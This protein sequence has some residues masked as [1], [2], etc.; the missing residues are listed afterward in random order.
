MALPESQ[1]AT[2]TEEHTPMEEQ[3]SH[4]IDGR[5]DVVLVVGY[6]TKLRVSSSVLANASE[7]FANLL[8]SPNFKEGKQKQDHVSEGTQ[9]PLEVE[10][11]EDEPSGMLLLC[12]LLHHRGPTSV[13]KLSREELVSIAVLANKYLIRRQFRYMLGEAIIIPAP[14]QS[15]HNALFD[16]HVISY[17]LESSKLFMTASDYLVRTVKLDDNLLEDYGDS[18]VWKMM[19]DKL[20]GKSNGVK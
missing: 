2:P 16:Y 12:Q 5:G 14:C 13:S 10:L 18:E 17:L 15:D 6:D 1:A 9:E 20:L 19:P 8:L 11:P 4:I 3:K 7:P